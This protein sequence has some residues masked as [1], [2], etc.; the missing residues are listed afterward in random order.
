MWS[1]AAESLYCMI[2]MILIMFV[3]Q[4]SLL[5]EELSI[6]QVWRLFQNN[7]YKDAKNSQGF[8]NEEVHGNT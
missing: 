8:D 1:Y 2:K 3:N 5:Q 7:V 6:L 4:P